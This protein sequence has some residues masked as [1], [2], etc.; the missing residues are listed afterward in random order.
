MTRQDQMD[1]RNVER[2][3]VA[4]ERICDYLLDLRLEVERAE[5]QRRGR[6]RVPGP[7]DSG[8][9]GGSGRARGGAARLTVH[10]CPPPSVAVD[11]GI[12]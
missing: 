12:G 10:D 7:R 3:A 6:G 5:R 4:L 11:C 9:G 1:S 8:F 2:C